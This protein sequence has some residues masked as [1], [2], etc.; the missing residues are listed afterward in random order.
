M[1]SF[2]VT[3]PG[4][5]SSIED[6]KSTFEGHIFITL[7]ELFHENQQIQAPTFDGIGKYVLSPLL[8]SSLCYWGTQ[9]LKISKKVSLVEFSKE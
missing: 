2:F 1:H 8:E 9:C 5:K 6:C 7:M 3:R 4:M